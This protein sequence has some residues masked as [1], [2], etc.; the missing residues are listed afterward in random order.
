MLQW[1][2][3]A[4][5]GDSAANKT[6]FRAKPRRRDLVHA[7]DRLTMLSQGCCSGS[8]IGGMHHKNPR[9]LNT[10]RPRHYLHVRMIF[11]VVNCMLKY[12]QRVEANPF[13]TK[14]D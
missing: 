10:N 11:M 7:H 14:L 4:A 1:P 6:K 13:A 12:A 3:A 9:S 2:H 5:Q 8:E